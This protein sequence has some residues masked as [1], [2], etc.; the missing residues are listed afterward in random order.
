VTVD[1]VGGEIVYFEVLFRDDVRD[2]L[3][4][5]FTPAHAVS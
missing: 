1:V 4:R 5:A 3:A 2:G